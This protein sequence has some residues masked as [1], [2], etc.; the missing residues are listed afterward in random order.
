MKSDRDSAEH[1]TKHW[2]PDNNDSNATASEFSSMSEQ[3]LQ[4]VTNCISDILMSES[5]QHAL[6]TALAAVAQVVHLDRMVVIEMKLQAGAFIPNRFFLWE[7]PDGAAQVSPTIFAGDSPHLGALREWQRPLR[8]GKAIV[9]F[10]RTSTAAVREILTQLNVVSVLQVPILIKGVYWGH[11]AF[12]DYR[13]ERD[14]TQTEINVLKILAE[15]IGAAVTRERSLEELRQRDA[16][17]GAVTASAVEIMTAP[18]LHEAISKSLETVAKAVRADRMFVLEVVQSSGHPQIL[19]RNSW[20]AVNVSPE[21]DTILRAMSGPAAAEILAWAAPLQQGQAVKGRLSAIEGALKEFFIRMKLQS[22]LLVPI[23]V[24]GKYWGH[25][26]FDDCHDERDWTTTEV[27]ILKTLAQLIGTAITRERFVEELGK[28]NTIVQNSPTILYRLRGEPSFPMIYISQNIAL[29]GLNSGELLNS[30]TLYQTYVHPEDRAKVQ[31]TM[32]ELLR[33]N[34]QPATIEFRMMSSVGVS[35]WMEN[36]YTPVRD[37]NGRLI[38]VE[39]IMIDI[40]ERKL[41]EDRISLLARTDALTSLANRATFN[42]RLRQ[43]FA[44]AKRG[45][46]PFA[47]LY[48]DL[49]RFKE[50]NDTRGHPVGD[51]LLQAVAERLR[52]ATRETD[53]VARLGGDEFAILQTDVNDPAFSGTLATKVVSALSAPYVVD[54]HEVRIGASVG[55]SVF[56]PDAVAPDTLL[57]Q[58]DQALYRA[59]EEGRGQYRFHSHE[60]DE[61]ARELVNLAEDLRSAMSRNELELYYQP[62]VE[63]SSGRIVGMEALIRWKHPTRGLLLPDVFLPIAE[64]SGMTLALGRWV[65]DGACKQLAEWRKADVVVPVIAVNVALAQ[66]KTGK[67]FVRDVKSSLERWGLKP[68]DLELDVTEFILARTTLAQSDVL[69]ELRRLGVC[70][71][72]DDFGAQ[73]SSLDYLRTYRVGRLKI[74][75]PMVNAA[76]DERGGSAMIRA[77]MSLANELGVEVIAEGVETEA[78]RAAIVSMSAKSKGQ[79]FF[80]SRPMPAEDTTE[81]LR[82]ATFASHEDEPS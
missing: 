75:R 70:I 63:L 66:I 23:M 78:Q 10:R 79:G 15:L 52:N 25:V 82:L 31:T 19:L 53:L 3:L 1:A 16:V 55:I 28:A 72:I 58:A 14:W 24:D 2:V 34:A 61:E 5:V 39:G 13:S 9:A 12:D 33:K 41:A 22:T 48:L 54:G 65:L 74:A 43:V 42:D 17:L 67:E 51:K 37:T 18:Y 21:L 60:L 20:H 68:K 40:T 69:E 76:A 81:I 44:A 27:D 32:V 36:R 62:Q 56:S 49:D 11:I 7:T 6:P 57:V 80:F 26:S 71:A 77:I 4:T 47:V 38:E 35:H 59:K 30:P 8:E 29:L 64:K 45:A 50:V 73:Y 46:N